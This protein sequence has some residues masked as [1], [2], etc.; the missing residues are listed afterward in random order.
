M[1]WLTLRWTAIYCV[2]RR[3]SRRKKGLWTHSSQ[4][5]VIVRLSCIFQTTSFPFMAS[6]D[7]ES[8]NHAD[9]RE[10]KYDAS[11][12]DKL[13]GLAGVRQRPGMYIGPTDERG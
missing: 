3:V 5:R 9:P 1:L 7:A 11:K 2:W 4:P 10:Q 12:I 6:Q 13:E 8:A